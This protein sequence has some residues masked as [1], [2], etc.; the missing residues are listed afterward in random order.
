MQETSARLLRLLSLLQAQRSW[1][2]TELASRLRVSARTVR[3]DVDRLR[4]LGYPVLA[5]RGSVGG[6]RLGAGAAMPPLL[7]DDEEAVAVVLGLRTAVRGAVAG[8]EEASLRALAKLEQV[9][10]GRL[11]HR[12]GALQSVVLAVPPTAASAPLVDPELLMSIA[13]ACR[14]RSRLRFSYFAHDGRPSERDV[15]PYRL[16]NWGRRWYLVAFDVARDDW[17]IF[18]V[19]RISL[20]TPGGPRFA[21]RPLPA[22]DLAEYVTRRVSAAVM[23]SRARVTVFGPAAEVSSRIGP[24]VT[25]TPVSASRCVVDAGSDNAEMLAAYLGMIG[26]DF[27]VREPPELVAALG[28]LADRYRRAISLARYLRAA[29]VG[30]SAG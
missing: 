3:N 12:V 15:E 19:D 29:A 17:R 10:P 22:D 6:Y 21:P 14:D 5:D 26:F 23:Q 25:V 7:L 2:G 1:T 24:G 30:S 8:I 11:R 27:E 4:S 28:V 16:V 13:A 18:R 20:R 9:L